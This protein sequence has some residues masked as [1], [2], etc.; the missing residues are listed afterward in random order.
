MGRY[1]GMNVN[2]TLT[3]LSRL[4]IEAMN[5]GTVAPFT[6]RLRVLA[7]IRGLTLTTQRDFQ[8][9]KGTWETCG[10]IGG[11]MWDKMGNIGR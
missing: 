1:V 6:A 2:T 9:Y 10:N 5:A 4:R 8:N 7:Q 11:K 3:A